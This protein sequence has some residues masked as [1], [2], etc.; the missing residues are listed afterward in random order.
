M[1][2]S[3]V[4][5]AILAM[6]VSTDALF[7]IRHKNTQCAH[8]K[9]GDRSI[10]AGHR[11]KFDICMP[12]QPCYNQ[13][14]QMYPQQ[15]ILYPQQ[16]VMYPQQ[17]VMYPQQHTVMPV[18]PMP[19]QIYPQ[20]QCPCFT[21]VCPP[22]QPQPQYDVVT[23]EVS[24]P[25]QITEYVPVTKT[26]EQ[27]FRVQELVPR[28]TVTCYM[29]CTTTTVGCTVCPQGTQMTNGVGSITQLA[30][31]APVH[32]MSPVINSQQFANQIVV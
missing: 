10:L 20:Q 22:C 8:C 30:L 26:V 31:E 32:N 5:S 16:Q 7:G 2:F 19:T 23:K 25:R 6:T 14:P 1:K 17:Q 4:V 11:Q 3:A 21:P 9:I 12:G 28:K 15:Q 29:T 27:K 18:M 24:V 13:Y